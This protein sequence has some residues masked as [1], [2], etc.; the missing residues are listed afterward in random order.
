MRSCF[1]RLVVA[2]LLLLCLGEYAS[3]CTCAD[4]DSPCASFQ[5]TPVVFVGLVKS[6]E[7]ETAEINRFGTIEKVRTALTAHFVVEEGLKG[8]S[9]REVDVATGGGG[10]DCGYHF[11]A[12]E[13]YLVYAHGTEQEALGSSMSRTVVGGG[14]SSPKVAALAT[15]ICSRTQ[16][17][18]RAQDDL[19]LIRAAI[20]GEPKARVFG[21]VYE[22]VSKLGGSLGDV[23]Y[24]PKAGLAIKA[25]GPSGRSEATTDADGRFR[26]DN[27]K[28]GKYTVALVLPPAYE[29]RYSFRG[30]EFEVQ[31]GQ[32]C[33]GAD[34][35]F[36]IHVS[37]RIKG[38]IFDAQGKP[39]GA[40]VQVSIVTYESA[41]QGMSL[42][43]SRDEYTDERGRYEFDGVPP[44]RYLLGINIADV[45]D[46]DTPYSKLYYPSG[47]APAQAAVIT[48]AEGQQLDNH[49]F[50][51]AQP[52]A[53]QTITG[54]VYLKNGKP[55][56][57]ADLELYD[58]ERPER[59]VWG[60]N[61]K[62]DRQGRF[63][64]K[65][66]RGRRYQLRAY[67]AEDYLI[68]KGVQSD[69]V[70]V[71]AALSPPPVKLILSKPGIFR[72]QQ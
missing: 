64:V 44:G 49:D 57:G 2:S 58:L 34:L 1:V 62:T 65:G 11:K 47:G 29:M 60:V 43:E 63:T 41:G 36:T 16:P 56:A 68:G 53:G 32:G 38:R 67:L 25:D 15:S 26:L 31:V 71:D 4:S 30:K 13:R 48:L 27:L 21:T 72:H 3:A 14:S 42:A 46:K 55:A 8:I 5:A 22:H 7:E 40:Q 6:I 61:V 24:K 37:G 39:V 10:G 19:E 59:S 51:L 9:G 18:S 33:W 12:G 28:P 20:K 45:A 66:F 69:M 23:Q 52:L 17:L 54:T 35:F 50:H 70:D